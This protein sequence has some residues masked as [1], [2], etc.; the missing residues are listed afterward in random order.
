[1]SK[2]IHLDKLVALSEVWTYQKGALMKPQ[3][4][5]NSDWQHGWGVG[6]EKA[7]NEW[8]RVLTAYLPNMKLDV[9]SPRSVAEWLKER[10]TQ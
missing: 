7:N 9:Y 3:Q 6:Y 10:V 5:W 8:I 1:M 4:S 2:R